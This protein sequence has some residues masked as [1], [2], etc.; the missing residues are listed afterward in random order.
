MASGKERSY[1]EILKGCKTFSDAVEQIRAHA[2]MLNT[3]AEAASSVLKDE[4]AKKNIDSIK[5]LSE[6]ILRVTAQGEER[7]R[8]LERRMQKEKDDFESLR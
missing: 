3:E 5:E 6:T 2:K 7:V 4:V 1:E 8:E